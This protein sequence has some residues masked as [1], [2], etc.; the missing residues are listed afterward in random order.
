VDF[1]SDVAVFVALADLIVGN[2][3]PVVD[4]STAAFVKSHHD[5]PR[6]QLS[7]TIRCSHRLHCNK[8][9]RCLASAPCTICQTTHFFWDDAFM[10]C[11]WVTLMA[12]LSIVMKCKLRVVSYFQLMGSVLIM[13]V[14]T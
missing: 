12:Y 5:G 8:Y 6:S 14:K 1:G 4:S 9:S 11:A 13:F 7:P 2:H 10:L 3:A